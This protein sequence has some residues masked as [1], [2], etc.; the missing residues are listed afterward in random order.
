MVSLPEGSEGLPQKVVGHIGVLELIFQV[1]DLPPE[2]VVHLDG[3][4]VLVVLQLH[5]LGIHMVQL[6]LEESFDLRRNL[7][8]DL[9]D[10]LLSLEPLLLKDLFGCLPVVLVQLTFVLLQ[11]DNLLRQMFL[12]QPRHLAQL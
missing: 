5:E 7:L 4:P 2:L 3:G 11:H 10:D 12:N 8:G 1:T 9:A 6:L